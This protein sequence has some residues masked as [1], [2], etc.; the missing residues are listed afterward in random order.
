MRTRLITALAAVIALTLSGC[1]DDSPDTDASELKTRLVTAQEQLQSGESLDISLATESLP[2]GVTAM[3]S[4]KGVGVQGEEPAFQGD[5]VVVTGGASIG[6]EVIAIGDTVWAK[7]GFSPVFLTIDPA[8]LKAPNPAALVGAPDEGL[9]TILSSTEELAAGDQSRDGKDVL[10]T[11]SGTIPGSVIA[12]FL[13]SADAESTF[14]VTYRLTDDD[15]LRDATITGKF[16]PGAP[17]VTYT[18]V[19]KAS[20]EAVTIEEPKR[21]GA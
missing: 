8:T 10:T 13:P 15:V 9:V 19:L 7:M 17:D 16:Y 1:T 12:S 11:I 3:L 18:V 4:A 6:A 21:P 14:E 20:D 2:S 5:V